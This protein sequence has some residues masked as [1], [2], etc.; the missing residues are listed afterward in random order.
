M[1]FEAR[2]LCT[3]VTSVDALA[4]AVKAVVE[5]DARLDILV[6]NAALLASGEFSRSS[7]ADWER[8]IAVS[9]MIAQGH[10]RIISIAS[11][12]A[13]RGGGAIGSV[14]YGASIQA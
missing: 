5:R 6:C 2:A 9:T 12:A 13:M 14:L 3:D 11:V 10:G 4:D 1:S 8:I 7:A